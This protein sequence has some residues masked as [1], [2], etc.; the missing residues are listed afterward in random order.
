MRALADYLDLVASQHRGA[1]RFVDALTTLLSL[2]DDCRAAVAALPADF[3]LDAATGVQLDVIGK[4]VGFS[5]FLDAPISGVYFA[6]DIEGVGLDQGTWQGQFDPT[7]GV[8]RLD[9]ETYR[10]LMRVKIAANS[11]DGTIPS[12]VEILNGVFAGTDTPDAKFYIEDHQN[13]SM[14]VGISGGPPP[15]LFAALLARGYFRLKP[16]GVQIEYVS[17]SEFGS[18]V[19]GLD[20]DSVYVSG[21]DIGAW[22][23][24]IGE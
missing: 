9:D 1:P 8:V 10:K 12:A 21:L 17:S 2:A 18:P 11:W 19:F 3:D 5:R 22:A 13:M 6:L 20:V 23:I 24:P 7:D 14:L 15:A 4:W 16:V